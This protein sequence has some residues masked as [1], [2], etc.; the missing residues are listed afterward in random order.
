MDILNN[1]I[2]G[3]ID[4]LTWKNFLW[5]VSG[6]FLGTALGV[7]PG[8]GPMTAMTLILPLAFYVDP[9]TALVILSATYAGAIYGGSTASI[10][11]NLPG[12]AASSITCIDGYPMSLK[13]K[14][15]TAMMI[16]AATSFIGASVGI[17]LIVSLAPVVANLALMFGPTEYFALMLFAFS[18]TITVS[19]ES[20]I[21]NFIM[22]ALGIL[23][24]II[25]TDANS[26]ILRFN[27]GFYQLNDGIS[28]ILITMGLFGVAEIMHKLSTD[29]NVDIKKISGIWPTKDEWKLAIPSGLRG[30]L[31]GSFFGI[32]PGAGPTIST[33]VGYILEKKISKD[34]SKFGHGAVEGIAGPE[35]ANNAANQTAYIPTLALGIPGDAAMPLILAVLMIHG[36]QPGP[37]FIATNPDLFWALCASFVLGNVML[38]IINSGMIQLWIKVLEIPYTVLYPSIVILMCIGAYTVNN[39]S[40]DILIMLSFGVL[41]YLLKILSFNLTPAIIGF[42]VGPGIEEH[43]RRS[44]T[45]SQGD[46]MTFFSSTIST[47]FLIMSVIILIW[48]VL[49]RV[50][51]MTEKNKLL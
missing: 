4:I 29:L 34:S 42:V 10:L 7:L 44:L 48:P 50:L 24:G 2:T 25:G 20:R 27:L 47:V 19:T 9:L 41:G 49:S 43:F 21:K 38:L 33:F 17:V 15:G 16:T 31:T 45:I 22:L 23:F 36:I 1:F 18:A 46:F 14:G 6:A 3:A 51:H 11:L 13:G 37:G 28:I 40:F 26:G 32:L 12:T 8:I 5:C 39:S 35:A 30:S